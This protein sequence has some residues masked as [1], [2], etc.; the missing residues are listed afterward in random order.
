MWFWEVF[1]YLQIEQSRAER[2]LRMYVLSAKM[3]IEHFKIQ[4]YRGFWNFE[5]LYFSKQV[6]LLNNFYITR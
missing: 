6:K 4:K 2:V 1:S 3:Q 5:G